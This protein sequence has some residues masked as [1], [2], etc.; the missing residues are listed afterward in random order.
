MVEAVGTTG[1]GDCTIAGFLAAVVRKAS[2]ADCLTAAV[3]TGA[4]SVEQADAT[5]GVQGWP[6]CLHR[7]AAGW[8]QR[9]PLG[10]VA[11]WPRAAK[12]CIGPMDQ[13]RTAEISQ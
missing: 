13:T 5:S 1:S 10:T 4:C 11:D 12:I 9:E 7:I 6:Q 3:A 2:P 8:D